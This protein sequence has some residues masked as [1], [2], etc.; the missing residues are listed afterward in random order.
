M[1]WSGIQD[2][3]LLLQ[4][5]HPSKMFRVG[6]LEGL[7]ADYFVERVINTSSSNSINIKKGVGK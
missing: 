6:Q 5:F 4:S 7:S 1:P 2:T 3:K